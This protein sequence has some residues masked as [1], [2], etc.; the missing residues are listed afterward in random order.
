MHIKPAAA[1]NSSLALVGVS[2]A[3]R[4]V[5]LSVIQTC[6]H[7]AVTG[8]PATEPLDSIR[9]DIIMPISSINTEISNADVQK[10]RAAALL[11]HLTVCGHQ[12]RTSS[13]HRPL[14]RSW[15]AYYECGRPLTL[16]PSPLSS[17]DST[18]AFTPSPSCAR[19]SFMGALSGSMWLFTAASREYLRW[20]WYETVCW[21]RWWC[22]GKILVRWGSMCPV[23]RFRPTSLCSDAVPLCCPADR[24]PDDRLSTS[25]GSSSP[26]KT[27]VAFSTLPALAWLSNRASVSRR[28]SI[29]IV[30]WQFVTL[31]WIGICVEN[32]TEETI[33]LLLL[34]LL[35]IIIITII[36]I[37][38]VKKASTHNSAN[39]HAG[40]VCESWPWSLTFWPQNKLI[41]RTHCETFLCQVW[42]S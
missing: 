22:A 36:I 24:T 23:S 7:R 35:R 16:K 42:W 18:L 33:L 15:Q 11:A 31:L 12:W 41:S 20:C 38:K 10:P 17:F 30:A 14:R 32:K 1:V 8:N 6:N 37:N 28:H 2:K 29:C 27:S 34:L 21:S 5:L 13:T 3:L 4:P 26:W 25:D 9:R 40:S 39:A 19:T